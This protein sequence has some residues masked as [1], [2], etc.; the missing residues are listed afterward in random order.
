MEKSS[1]SV[2]K[3]LFIFV[4]I[5]PVALVSLYEY[6]L[7]TN[8]YQSTA[9]IFITE[10]STQ[11]SPLD[12]SL[13]GITSSGSSRDILVL[14]AFIESPSLLKKIDTEIQLRVHFSNHDA[15][16]WSKLADDA[17]REDFL[18]YYLQRVTAEHD[19]E[20]Q[21]L[22]ISVQTFNREYSKKLINLIL[23]K[24]QLFI[25]QLNENVSRS[26]L[27]FFESEV[28]TS[29][30]ILAREKEKLRAFQKKHKFLS[31]E[32]SSKAIIGTISALEQ[33]L[34]EKKSELNSRIGLLSE[35]S[36]TLRR[37][38]SQINAIQQQIIDA[39]N[40]LASSDKGS[41]SELDAQFR[42]HVLLVEF[43]TLRYKANLDALAKAQVEAARRLRFLTIVS[44]PTLADESLFPDRPYVIMTTALI[45]LMLFFIASISLATIRE[46]A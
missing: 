44:P 10:E 4:F 17:T 38:R 37:F 3:I 7:A 22:E 18:Q 35:D 8:R 16:F 21:L 40:R 25:D 5:L 24:S 46:H 27:N 36:P 32:A 20:A 2:S 41:V 34:A 33:S 26:Q 31:T 1:T 30:L 6:L 13:L 23:K 29:E 14:K 42:D 39:N 43:K 12:L 28:K 9:S 45:A 19:D 15:D 11:S